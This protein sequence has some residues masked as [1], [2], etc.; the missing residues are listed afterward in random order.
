VTRSLPALRTRYYRLSHSPLD[1][2]R[3]LGDLLVVPAVGIYTRLIAGVHSEPGAINHAT[4]VCGTRFCRARDVFF[5]CQDSQVAGD[6]SLD[7]DD[8]MVE[9][10]AAEHGPVEVLA[11]MQKAIG[12]GF[13]SVHRMCSISDQGR[14]PVQAIPFA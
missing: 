1:H 10:F 5:T 3:I 7:V 4:F 13:S 12:F 9:R 8:A 2:G 14:S 11:C 6:I